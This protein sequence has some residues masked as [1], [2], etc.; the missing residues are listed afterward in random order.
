LPAKTSGWDGF[1]AAADPVSRACG[2]AGFSE[3]DS[4]IKRV[5]FVPD[6]A[7]TD[8]PASARLTEDSSLLFGVEVVASTL[9]SCLFSLLS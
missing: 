5:T 2:I 1:R 8:L 4:E 9:L 7:E 6:A 3:G